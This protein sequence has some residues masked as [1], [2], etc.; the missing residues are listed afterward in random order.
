MRRL[1]RYF[2]QGVSDIR[3]M[4]F[5]MCAVLMVVVAIASIALIYNSFSISL[6]ERT[7]Q[8]G[9][10]KSIGATRFQVIDECFFGGGLS[11]SISDTGRIANWLC[12]CK[13]CISAFKEQF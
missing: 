6:T 3:Y 4:L 8:F 1:L 13:L 5:G 9:L 2:G 7:R 10:F 12:W 11:G